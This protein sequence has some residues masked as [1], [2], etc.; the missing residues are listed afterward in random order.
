MQ[1]YPTI[2]ER[3]TFTCKSCGYNA[4]VLG[5]MYFDY[6]CYNYLAT[7]SCDECKTLFESQICQVE[8]WYTENDFIY[9]LN[10][11]I[12][13]L[14]CSSKRTRIWKKSISRCP[15]CSGEM[16]YKVNGYIKVHG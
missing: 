4:Q 14:N 10:D 3:R 7:F 1:D 16:D 12:I 11:D 13:C 15:K 8:D 2:I 5:E 9:G 6:G